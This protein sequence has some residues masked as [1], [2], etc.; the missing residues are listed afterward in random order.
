MS[1]YYKGKRTRNLYDPHADTPFV[2]SRSR[3]DLFLS[4]P[5][6]F[7]IDRRL[8]VDRPPGYPFAIN[9]AVDSLLKNEFDALRHEGKTHPLIEQFGVD[10]RP[11]AH[12][13]LNVWREN[14]KGVRYH[15]TRNNFIVTGAIDDL[16]IN[17]HDEYIVVDYK[18]TAKSEPVTQLGSGG[19]HDA[20]RRQMEVYQWLLRKNGLT[21]SDTGYFVYCTGQPDNARFDAHVQFDMN[22]IAY[23]GDDGWV[24]DVLDAIKST[25]DADEIPFAHAECD[26]CLYVQE[27]ADVERVS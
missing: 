4:C 3:I 18:S 2:L 25:L 21:V 1:Q 13:E 6:C 22:I 16:W 14:F 23:T 26:Y 8:G 19:H 20:Y 27:R 9:A 12:E 15:D 5:R 10:A 11:V 24:S 7:Y 17:S